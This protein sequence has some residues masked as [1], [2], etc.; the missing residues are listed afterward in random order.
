MK[1]LVYDAAGNRTY[2]DN[3]QTGGVLV[4]KYVLTKSSRW[5]GQDS[6]LRGHNERHLRGRS[7]V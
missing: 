5:L 7:V 2:R 3:T 6:S 4:K 1:E